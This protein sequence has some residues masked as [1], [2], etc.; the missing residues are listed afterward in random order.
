MWLDPSSNLYQGFPSLSW[1]F[2]A[3]P[4]IEK[5]KLLMLVQASCFGTVHA[6]V[7]VPVVFLHCMTSAGTI[8]VG[9]TG[10]CSCLILPK[11]QYFGANQSLNYRANHP[12]LYTA[13]SASQR[14]DTSKMWFSGWYSVWLKYFSKFLSK[15]VYFIIHMRTC[16]CCI[17]MDSSGSCVQMASHSYT[18][19]RHSDLGDF[20]LPP[21][22][23]YI[24]IILWS[25][26]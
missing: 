3:F 1:V 20:I 12:L 25:T 2:R 18:V 21:Q 16:N 17:L 23:F 4:V 14:D 26:W 24:E 13:A 11:W 19:T 15:L 7:L 8:S 6:V 22:L 9:K 5:N 10:L